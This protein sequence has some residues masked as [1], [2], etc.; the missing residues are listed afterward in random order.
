MDDFQDTL[1]LYP[2]NAPKVCSY[3]T[4]ALEDFQPSIAGPRPL[5]V[6]KSPSRPRGR[7]QGYAPTI[8]AES[9]CQARV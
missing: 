4:L 2:G 7:P 1:A 5:G 8:D 3:Y 9:A 6:T